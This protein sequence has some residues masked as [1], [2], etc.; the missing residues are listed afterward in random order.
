MPGF[1]LGFDYACGTPSPVPLWNNCFD[2]S[3]C[4]HKFNALYLYDSPVIGDYHE[5]RILKWDVQNCYAHSGVRSWIW[6]FCLKTLWCQTYFSPSPFP[7]SI[8]RTSS[9]T[10]EQISHWQCQT[11]S[12]EKQVNYGWKMYVHS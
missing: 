11:W 1:G 8:H 10:M 5:H 3:K 4:F 9:Q 7:P 6:G 2:F 12:F